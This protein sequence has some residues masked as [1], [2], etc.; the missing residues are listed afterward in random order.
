MLVRTGS[1]VSSVGLFLISALVISSGN[2]HKDISVFSGK[3]IILLIIS[4]VTIMTLYIISIDI[5]VSRRC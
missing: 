4:I 5:I 1:L 3:R 2:H